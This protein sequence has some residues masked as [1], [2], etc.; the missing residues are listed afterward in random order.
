MESIKSILYDVFKGLQAQQKQLPDGDLRQLWEQSAKGKIAKH[1]KV[2]FF[3][4]GKLFVNV[5]NSGWL[6]ELNTKKE[7]IIKHLKKIS[8]NKIKDIKL[9]VGDVKYGNQE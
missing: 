8:K 5:E 3:K 9:K 1:T 7:D 2:T 6:Y 4:N